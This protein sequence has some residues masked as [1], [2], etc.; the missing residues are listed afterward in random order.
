MSTIRPSGPCPAK[1]M[2]VLDFPSERDVTASSV[3]SDYAGSEFGKMLQEAGLMRGVCFT[4]AF[5]QHRPLAN[6]VGTVIAMKKTDVSPSHIPVRDKMALP[7]VRDAIARL[8]QE[9]ELCRPN[10]I[11]ALGNAAMWA[12]TGKWGITNWRGSVLQTDLPLSLPWQPKVIPTFAPSSIFKNW[13][14]RQVAVTDLRRVAKEAKTQEYIRPDYKFL[15]QVDY[16]TAVATLTRLI[17]LADRGHLKLAPDIETAHGHIEMIGIAWSKRE[18]ICI[19]FMR[20]G[21]VEPYWNEA[22]E[23]EIQWL[24]YR[25]L[26]HPNAQIV[27]QNF[28]YDAQYISRHW[29]YL[30]R[31]V[32]DTMLTA[33]VMFSSMQKDLAFLASLWCEHY[34]YWKEGLH[35]DNRQLYNCEDCVITYEV[36]EA[37]Q[38]AIDAMKLREVHDFQQ[39]LFWPVLHTM[40]RGIKPDVAQK[41]KFAETLIEEI[42]AREQWMIDVLG[43]PLNIKSPKQMT[44][45]FYGTLGQREVLGRKTGNPTCDDE[46]LRTIAEREPILRP[47]CNK[48]SELRS[49]GVFLSTFINAPLDVDGRIRCSFNIGGTETYRFSSSQNAF[50]SGLNLQNIPKGGEAGDGLELPNVRSLFVPDAGYTFFDIDLSS[51]DLRIVVWEADEPEFKAM[52]KEGADPYTEIAKEFYRDPTITK[53]DPRRQTFKAFAHGTNY[54]G[55]A[56]GLAE[57]L[58]LSVKDAES[59]Q[60]WY[61]GRFPRI[62][63]WQDDIKDQVL[64][65]RMVENI[66]GYRTQ[67][68]GRIEG[69]VF[70]QAVAWIPQSTV[71]CLINRAYVKIDQ[72]L[73]EVQVLL[74]V[75]DSLAGQFPTARADF[76]EK[77]IIEAAEIPLP[78]PGDPLTIGVGC[79]TSTRSW[80]ECG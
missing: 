67:F 40:L 27:G 74:Q 72:T 41:G 75:H 78:Y 54:L 11:I 3:M 45:L 24:L 63:K 2:V 5:L 58:G 66:F 56:K 39:T 14:W 13:D 12:L 17:S 71:A 22:E 23:I 64:K 50:G 46:A 20:E 59:T 26:T 10:V 60:K 52:L 18:A 37:Q 7:H 38:P 53:K 29:L 57:R 42:A 19:P 80:G 79:K 6:D 35:G 33:H 15:T 36:D 65:R 61:F 68:L 1:I 30:P 44:E 51:A 34:V 25:L 73:P 32:R 48:I 69:T 8:T 31:L 28:S 77:A 21:S 47:L 43:E 4:T 70:N 55:S 76:Y 62:K 49:L 16:G 9:I